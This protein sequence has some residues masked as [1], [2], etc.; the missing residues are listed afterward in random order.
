MAR[1]PQAGAS[2]GHGDLPGSTVLDRL[3]HALGGAGRTAARTSDD[4]LDCLAV[5]GDRPT[6]DAVDG[7]V[8]GAAGL[9]REISLATQ[10]LTLGLAAQRRPGVGA[11]ERSTVARHEAHR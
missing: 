2:D 8:D 5:L 7:L 4:L 10:E 6:Q 1:T 3:A 11:D 9:L